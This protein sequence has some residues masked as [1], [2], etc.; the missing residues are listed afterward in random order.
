MTVSVI[1]VNWNT[2]DLLRRCLDALPAALEGH[3][4]E[5]LV[6][7]NASADQSVAR[8][9][10][11][12]QLFRLFALKTNVGFARANNIGIRQAKGEVII[13][14]NPDTEPS[15]GS[16]S[17]LA[18]FLRD[19]PSAAAVG[20]QLTN[21][22]GTLQTSCR[23]FPTTLVLALLFLKVHH[24][25]PSLPPLRRYFMTDFAHDAELPVDQIMGACMAIPRPE[26][27]RVGLLDERYWIWFEEVDWCRR[28]VRAGKQIWFTPSARVLHHGGVS[29]RQVL[30]VQKE[31]RLIRSGLRYATTHIG[32]GSLAVLLP[33][34]PIA[35]LL[36]TGAF[37]PWI[38]RSASRHA[39]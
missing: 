27:E 23:R 10:G 14:L 28:A 2:G 11:S 6:V 8:A 34:V 16:L 19:H 7:D 9:E 24:L 37:L 17:A 15:P 35:L 39:R 1:I 18:G 32:A 21:P 30:P 13:L 29:F 3:A 4:H 12:P 22:D 36:D 25:L 31:W 38:R 26:F 5:V 33:L 20:P